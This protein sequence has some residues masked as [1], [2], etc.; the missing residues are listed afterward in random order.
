[1]GRE[2]TIT[3][4]QVH[5]A[6]SAIKT[7]GGK[8]TLRAVRERLGAGSMG[9]INKLLNGWKDLQERQIVANLVLPPA[10]QRALLDFMDVELSAARAALEG[11]IAELQQA[12]NDLAS[13]NER[14][15]GA[16]EAQAED[17][18]KLTAE[19]AAAEGKAV[20]LADDLANARDESSRERQ[21]AEMTRT[22]LAK[23]LLRLEAMPELEEDLSHARAELE[24]VREGRAAAQQQAAVLSAEK[25]SLES[26]LNDAKEDA[27][28]LQE[29]LQKAQDRA[30]RFGDEL[31]DARVALQ[32]QI[33][34][35]EDMAAKLANAHEKEKQLGDDLSE[36]QMAVHSLELQRDEL[37]GQ[38]GALKVE[39]QAHQMAQAPKSNATG[40]KRSVAA[41][42]RKK[43]TK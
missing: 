12:N 35:A 2:A 36:A 15:A 23:A 16:I 25:V 24:K 18:A 39:L 11:E 31:S 20:Q 9:T 29:Q 22:E 17:L 37:A 21:A 30:D 8:P 33:G 40:R 3:A 7:E 42:E 4:E 10:L 38:V 5:A 6:A 28:K 34:R 19:K 1:M 27:L 13:E 41:P 32:K 26:R 14:Q 43:E